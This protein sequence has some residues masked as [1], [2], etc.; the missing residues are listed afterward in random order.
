MAP[1]NLEQLAGAGPLDRFVMENTADVV[2]AFHLNANV[3]K[4]LGSIPHSVTTGATDIHGRRMENGCIRAGHGDLHLKN[5]ILIDDQRIVLNWPPASSPP[6]AMDLLEDLSSLLIE[7]NAKGQISAANILFNRYFD[8]TGGVIDDPDT[9]TALDGRMKRQ[10]R[11]GIAVPRLIAVG[12]LSGG[13]KSRMARELAPF[14]PCAV[15][16]RVVR[17]D[18][19]RKRMMGIGITERLHS[20]GYTEAI[21]EQTYGR[22]YEELSRAL[23]QGYPVIA[24]GVFAMEKQRVDVEQIA[25][26]YGV[27]FVGL[28]VEAPLQIRAQRVKARKNN[29][30]DVTESVLQRQV[31][32]DLGHILWHRIDSSGAKDKTLLA[33]RHLVGV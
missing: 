32:F 1:L 9:L 20:Q 14:I 8:V 15:G 24:D 18:V 17:T 26:K 12:G 11:P 21:T 13:G 6:R 19:V 3:H 16:A 5:I 31:N 30:S 25:H 22:F 23:E 27:P 10:N 29:V 7:L 33:G 4:D 28:W 2:A